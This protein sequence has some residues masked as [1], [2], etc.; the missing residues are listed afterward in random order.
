M[1]Q[2]Q[3]RPKVVSPV[4]P[5]FDN[6]QTERMAK[7]MDLKVSQKGKSVVIDGEEMFFV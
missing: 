5:W 2:K 4:R 6:A 7:I 1:K 3:K